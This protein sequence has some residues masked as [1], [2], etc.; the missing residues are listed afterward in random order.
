MMP[1]AHIIQAISWENKQLQLLDQRLLPHKTV[2]LEF[3]KVTAVAGA[4][5]DMV[6]RGAPAIGITAAYGI[7]LA[8]RA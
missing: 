2:Y 4:I 8:A 1:Q 7:V 3:D 5:R 6:V